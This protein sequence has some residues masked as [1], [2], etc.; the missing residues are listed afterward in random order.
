MTNFLIE[1]LKKT[2]SIKL[3]WPKNKM[4]GTTFAD[5]MHSMYLDGDRRWND[6]WLMWGKART[7]VVGRSQKSADSNNVPLRSLWK[8]LD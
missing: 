5:L 7:Q 6:S 1:S 8:E 3:K 2:Q 4:E